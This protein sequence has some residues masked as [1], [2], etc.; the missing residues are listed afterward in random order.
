MNRPLFLPLNRNTSH[1]FWRALRRGH[2]PLFKRRS[3]GAHQ[4]RDSKYFIH[5][6]F[7]R[8]LTPIPK[9]ILPQYRSWQSYWKWY[10]P[11]R[12]I[13]HIVTDTEANAAVLA[14][15]DVAWKTRPWLPICFVAHGEGDIYHHPLY[16]KW[17]ALEPYD[18]Y[19]ARNHLT[20]NYVAGIASKEM[21]ASRYRQHNPPAP[22]TGTLP[23]FKTIVYAPQ[24]AGIIDKRHN[25][26]SSATHEERCR[27]N[28]QILDVFN[29]ERHKVYWCQDPAL[30]K[31]RNPI[32]KYLEKA[33]Q[34]GHITW[35]K[36]RATRYLNRADVA[37]TDVGSAFL[38]EA[39]NAGKPVLCLYSEVHA[40]ALKDKAG[41]MFGRCL[42]PF[43][44][45]EEMRA[46]LINFLNC[47]RAEEYLPGVYLQV[48]HKSP[49]A[50]LIWE[51]R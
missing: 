20:R 31:E 12:K 33:H 47:R 48:E 45:P 17:L 41:P 34:L 49:N 37:M 1:F 14:A 5:N 24:Y 30:D 22:Y 36:D 23:E 26:V 11:K 46:K 38:F 21:I 4:G 9:D 50:K 8:D 43:D 7:Y 44:S 39:A 40:P 16:A 32:Y 25:L 3:I 2:L 42:Q 35:I 29:I 51:Q 19:Y 13:T 6:F 27:Y 18:C 28:R 15:M 10:L